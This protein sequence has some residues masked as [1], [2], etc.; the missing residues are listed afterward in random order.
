MVPLDERRLY[1]IAFSLVRGIG[2]VRFQTLL[3]HFGDPKI[4]WNAPADALRTAG[5]GEKI[6]E[7]LV[8]LRSSLSLD[9]LAERLESKGISVLILTDENYPRRLKEIEQPPPVLY[10]RGEIKP[11]DEWAVAVVGT[12]RVTAYGRQ[13]A[14]DIAGVLARNGVTVVSGLARGIDALAH[15]TALTAG[16]RTLAVLG[17]GV[18]RIYPSEHRGL[19]ERIVA[20]GALISDYAPGTPPDASNFPPRNRLISGLAM[21][22][23]VVEAGRTSG[24]LITAAF[25]ADQGREVFAVP[26]NI[27]APQSQ[28]T[29]RL[30]RDGAHPLLDPE[31][32]LEALELTRI[33]ENRAARIVLPADSTETALFEALCQ[34]PMHIDEIRA[35]SG[36]PIDQ[37]NAALAIMELKGLVRQVG[38]MHYVALREAKAPYSGAN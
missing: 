38:G 16:G 6:V 2:A 34:E 33:T 27:T 10:L 8:Q 1:W 37:V 24:A 31:E 36:L 35:R 13:V 29:N 32:V 9:R 17:S 30:I 19:A 5:L 22:V 12:R 21:A 18:D 15:Q 3:D 7:N 25:A 23:I 26:G 20:S 28:G 4:A 11:D 14:E